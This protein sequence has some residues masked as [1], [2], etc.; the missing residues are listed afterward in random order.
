MDSVMGVVRSRP[1]RGSTG[2][3]ALLHC[4]G[5]SSGARL[6]FQ[7]D[8]AARNAEAGC[9]ALIDATSISTCS[10]LDGWAAF[11][12][13]RGNESLPQVNVQLVVLEP[14][15]F[16]VALRII[17]GSIPDVSTLLNA[18][19]LLQSLGI[20]T[21]R[22]VVDRGYFSRANLDRLAAAGSKVVIPVPAHSALFASALREHGKGIRRAS[23]AFTDE[24]ET[25]YHCQFKCEYQGRDY[26]GHLYLNQS[27]QAAETSRL[28][29][30]IERAERSFA[31]D[32]PASKREA[33]AR[34]AEALPKTRARLLRLR[35][36]PEGLWILERKAKA[37]ARQLNRMGFMLIITDEPDLGGPETLSVY[38]SRDAAEKLFDN[39][40]NALE[41]DRLRV[42]SAETAEGKLFVALVAMMLHSLLQRR[43]AASKEALGRRVCPREA[44]VDLRRIKALLL[45]DGSEIFSELCKRQRAILRL[46]G[47]PEELLTSKEPSCKKKSI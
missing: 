38:R 37:I 6:R 11:G 10:S 19:R 7:K 44:L 1:A 22:V 31:D 25:Y 12:H 13:N 23:G 29:A 43:L 9:S 15:G 45:P 24:E 34:L 18:V 3:S 39:L 27:R 26:S 47:V 8:T 5:E 40:K 4:L 2:L 28:L 36:T 33:L 20:D 17:E 21:P 30:Q 35:R 32:P 42:H 14:G 16:P 41:L 46:L